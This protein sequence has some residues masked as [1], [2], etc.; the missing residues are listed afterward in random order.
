MGPTELWGTVRQAFASG[1]EAE[2]RQAVDEAYASEYGEDGPT[3]VDDQPCWEV[4]SAGTL[5][6]LRRKG[7]SDSW[8]LAI[9]AGEM[10]VSSARPLPLDRPWAMSQYWLTDEEVQGDIDLRFAVEVG[11]GVGST[12]L[13]VPRTWAPDDTDVETASEKGYAMS[14]LPPTGAPHRFVS[15]GFCEEYEEL[16]DMV[17]GK[18]GEDGQTSLSDDEASSVE[19]AV[20]QGFVWAVAVYDTHLVAGDR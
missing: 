18:V 20:H 1:T 16:L 3:E 11:F 7:S 13:K 17:L 19:L 4:L 10:M 15:A 9:F 8:K 14:W 5:D 2:W 6:E 12:L